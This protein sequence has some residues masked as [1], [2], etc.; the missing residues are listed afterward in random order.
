MKRFTKGTPLTLHWFFTK[1]DGETAFNIAGYA[2]ELYYGTG[3]GESKADSKT[4]DLTSGHLTWVFP[5][6]KQFYIGNYNLRLELYQNGAPFLRIDYKDA[7]CLVESQVVNTCSELQNAGENPNV[8]DLFTSSEY[9]RFTPVCPVIDTATKHWI[10]DG[11]DTGIMAGEEVSV[12][13]D[14]IITI[15]YG[16]DVT[17]TFTGVKD[18]I[19]KALSDLGQS[20]DAPSPIGSIWA[21]YNKAEQDRTTVALADHEKAV[22]DQNASAVATAGAEKVNAT[23]DGTT[24][25]VTNR[26]GVSRSANLKGDKGDKGEQGIP[27]PQGPQG[28]RG[29][30]GQQGVQGPQGP[31]GDKGEKGDTPA[32]EQTTGQATD[33]VMSQKAVTDELADTVHKTGYEEITGTKVFASDYGRTVIKDTGV[34]VNFPE[35]EDNPPVS[36]SLGYE[37]FEMQIDEERAE[38]SGPGYIITLGKEGIEYK[39]YNGAEWETTARLGADGSVSTINGT[40]ADIVLATKANTTDLTALSG[41]VD[42]IESVVGD[43]NEILETI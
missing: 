20:T 16:E 40:I 33:K 43:V 12:S 5:K 19:D 37:G 28:L 29:P 30:Q 18:T 34:Q 1:P 41:R 7:F 14:G 13:Q 4:V 8:V 24:I 22:A 27:G 10:V 38:E 25:T 39:K 23:L 21:R 31:K 6:D 15:K 35:P 17:I 32:I 3:R 9:Y 2:C 11:N 36:I 26:D 42:S